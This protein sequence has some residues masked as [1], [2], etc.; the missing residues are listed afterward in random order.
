MGVWF[1]GHIGHIGTAMR[2]CMGTGQEYPTSPVP[3]IRE[4]SILGAPSII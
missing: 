2:V 3:L 1:R 4:Y